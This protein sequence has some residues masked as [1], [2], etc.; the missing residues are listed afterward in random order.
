LPDSWTVRNAWKRGFEHWQTQRKEVSKGTGIAPGKYNDF[1]VHLSNDSRTATKLVPKDNGGNNL[2]LGEWIY[3]QLVTPDGTTSA[4]GFE[5]HMLGDHSGA[6]GSRVSVGLVKSYAESRVTVQSQ[7][8]PFQ[9]SQTADDPL[10]NI[11]DAGTHHDEVI[12]KIEDDND[13]PPYDV[14]IDYP[15]SS[16]NHPKPLVVQDTT[17]VDGR[18]VMG[19]FNAICGVLEIES[20]SSVAD[21]VYSVLVELAPGNYRGIAADVI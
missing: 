20:T 5:L 21:D 9:P 13:L 11:F 6:A 8:D 2:V 1:K 19:G 10:V 12:E 14:G 15:G 4:D 17:I 16:G 18:A 3:A 7:Q